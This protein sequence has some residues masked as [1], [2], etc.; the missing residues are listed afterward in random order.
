MSRKAWTVGSLVF[1]DL[2]L[3]EKRGQEVSDSHLMFISWLPSTRAFLR[4]RAH[5]KDSKQ[6]AQSKAG[7]SPSG[8]AY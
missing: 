3:E 7:P 1:L 4:P 2:D 5:D 8:S 6:G